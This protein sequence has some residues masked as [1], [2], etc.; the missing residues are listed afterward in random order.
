MKAKIGLDNLFKLN[1]L[2]F[3]LIYNFYIWHQLT[4]VSISFLLMFVLNV[5][6]YVFSIKKIEFVDFIAI[7]LI[8]CSF[9]CVVINGLH[10]N[11][12][13]SFS[14]FNKYLMFFNTIISFC[15][16]VKNHD[17]FLSNKSFFNYVVRLNT[18]SCVNT[19]IAF[20]YLGSSAY[21][22]NNV[23]AKYLCMNFENPN[24]FA[25]FITPIALLQFNFVLIDAGKIKKIIYCLLYCFMFYFIFESGSRNA[26][27]V[28]II[29]TISSLI[30]KFKYSK[31]SFIISKKLI[32]LISIFPILFFSIYMFFINSNFI[33]SY[34]SFLVSDGKGLDSRVMIWEK[35]I[36][37]FQINPLLGSYYEISDGTG[38][39][40]LHNT[41]V[42]VL[43]TYG[44]ISFFLFIIFLYNYYKYI[45][46]NK[47]NNFISNI[48]FIQLLLLT[49]LGCGEA[50]LFSGGTGFN[51][52]YLIFSVFCFF[53]GNLYQQSKT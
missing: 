43:T 39:S 28:L 9:V 22:M 27:L 49:F 53:D 16:L 40:Q 23:V 13:F 38:V 36:R 7:L 52:S 42:D 46:L 34:F 12:T 29:A 45:N 41:H 17:C 1:I 8:V 10:N 31:V 33:N 37:N 5:I 25:L 35:A 44:L 15:Y 32:F 2:L 26:Q 50:S 3:Y 14:Y 30:Y 19:I 47:K 20:K 4:I 6:I 21:V 11:V 18:I 48:F 51:V 24:K